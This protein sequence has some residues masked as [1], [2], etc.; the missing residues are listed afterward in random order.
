MNPNKG[1]LGETLRIAMPKLEEGIVLILGSLALCFSGHE[2]NFLVNNV[3]W[4]L[5]SR[6]KVKFAEEILQ[7][8]NAFDQC[9]LYEDLFLPKEG[10]ENMFLKGIQSKDLCK[11]SSNARDKKT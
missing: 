10:H 8:T 2:N 4:A 11:I 3:P 9:K 6:M 5:V 1:S 7:D